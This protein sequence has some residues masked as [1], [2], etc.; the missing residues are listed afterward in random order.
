MRV[1]HHQLS[2]TAGCIY[3]LTERK[4]KAVVI[5]VVLSLPMDHD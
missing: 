4:R 2:T 3:A 1:S 5:L